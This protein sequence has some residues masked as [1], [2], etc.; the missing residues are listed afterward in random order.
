MA[1][2]LLTRRVKA[3]VSK[4]G[5][6]SNETVA[7]FCGSLCGKDFKGVFSADYIPRR[8]AARGRFIVVVN[9]GTRRGV[10]G[11]LPM[12]HFITIAADPSKVLYVDPYGLPNVEPNVERF[13]RLCR[14]PVEFNLRQIQDTES[15]YCG[16]YAVLFS[17]YFDKKPDFKLRFRKRNLRKNDKL[18]VEYLRK[19][20]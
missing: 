2:K 20:M 11:K 19:M 1:E 18:C 15:V 13:L 16:L 5:G 9:L 17:L 12:G 6:I 14:R 10:R 3:N 7:R 8:L 4:E